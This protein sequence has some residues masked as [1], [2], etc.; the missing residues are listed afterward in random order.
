MTKTLKNNVKCDLCNNDMVCVTPG[1]QNYGKSKGDATQFSRWIRNNKKLDS[2]YRFTAHN[3]DYIWFNHRY[4][5]FI[6]IEEKRFMVKPDYS[7]SSVMDEIRQ[8][9]E[10]AA[11]NGV[12]VYSTFE[13]KNVNVKYNGHYVIMFEK[14][15]PDDSGY[16]M[17]NGEKSSI[18]RLEMLLIKGTLLDESVIS[19][20]KQYNLDKFV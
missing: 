6:T 13:R 5:W 8:I 15:G 12:T 16:C 3:L 11:G 18:S 19:V 20:L 7:Q 14:S 10:I 17:I 9:F 2:K 1:C 4:G